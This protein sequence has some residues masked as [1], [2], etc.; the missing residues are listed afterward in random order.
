MAGRVAVLHHPRSF[1][2]LDLREAVGDAAELLWVLVDPAEEDGWTRRLLRRLGTMVELSTG[3]LDAAAAELREYHP[4]GIVTFVD[5]NL[6]IAAELAARL[7]LTY[8]PPDVARTVASKWRQ[9]EALRAARVPGPPFWALPAG[10]SG[11][12]L[13]ALA[14]EVD[15]PAV[16]KPAAGSGSRGIL[17]IAGPADL[18]AAY[19]PDVDQIVEAYLDDDPGGDGRFASY[20]SVETVVSHAVN[21]HVAVTGR[22]P[23]AEPFRETGNFI[24]AAPDPELRGSLFALADAA[25]AALGITTGVLH[26]E[27]KLTPDGPQILEVNGRLGGRPPFVLRGV[28]DIN[29]FRVACEVAL[30]QPVSLNGPAS[31]RGVAYWRMLQPPLTARR[32]RDVAGLDELQAAPFV[33]TVR[34]T[35]APGD[36]VDWREGTDGQVVTIRGHVDDL[37]SL[38]EAIASIDRTVTI[39]YET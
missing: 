24:P 22:F 32:V 35:H 21:H 5:D 38:A 10:L 33:D 16:L 25:I 15:Y 30:D 17:S 12:E 11:A 13:S 7:G 8:H 39:A 1:F 23:L 28:S 20:L 19:R 31:C 14:D 3:D 37:D 4:D 29:L 36:D 18:V 26:I 2:P 34:L 27:I 9:R 6:V